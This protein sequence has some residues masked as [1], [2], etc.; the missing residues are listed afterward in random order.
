[1][2]AAVAHLHARRLR[3]CAARALIHCSFIRFASLARSVMIRLF[4]FHTRAQLVT[5]VVTQLRIFNNDAS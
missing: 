3:D 4:V 5:F 1:M 2:S